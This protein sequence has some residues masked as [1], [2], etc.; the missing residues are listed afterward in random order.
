MTDTLDLAHLDD[1]GFGALHTGRIEPLFA[2]A[3][4]E[5]LTHVATFRSRLGMG[6]PIALA[7]GAAAW[8][9]FNEAAA[10]VMVALFGLVVAYAIA[11]M[12]L[13]ALG[14]RV[15]VA[16]LDAIT[17][18]VGV[19][20]RVEGVAPPTMPRYRGLDL[21]P[22]FDRSR[23]EDF[24][25]GERL[26]CAFDIC[27]AVLEDKRRDKD[28]K[29][30]HVTVFRGQLVRIAFPKKFLGVTVV[31]RD[32]GVFNDLRALGQLKRVGLGDSTF[33]RAFEVYSNDQVEARY[34]VHPVFMERLIALETAYKGRNLRCA[35][36]EGDLLIAVESPDRFE[37]GDL[38]KP[39][40]DPERARRIVND[41]AEVMKLMDAV[42]TAERAPLVAREARPGKP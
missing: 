41:I 7:L 38:F 4:A 23:F 30:H 9:G 21:L 29:T 36:E 8:V 42:L 5:R 28:G 32:A 24:F 2:R 22:G 12:P 35:F 31:R 26:G 34:L 15:K 16:A 10:G 37:I 3:E 39:L 27:E 33:E 14:A 20:Y 25:H 40:A 17:G 18:A 11:Y 13:Q 1:A 19:T 6:A